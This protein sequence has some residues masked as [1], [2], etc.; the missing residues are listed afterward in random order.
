MLVPVDEQIKRLNA[1]RFQLD[2]M[3]VAGIT[4]DAIQGWYDTYIKNRKPVVAAIGDAKGTSL[5]SHVITSYSIHYTK[6]Y[7]GVLSSIHH[8]QSKIHYLAHHM[9]YIRQ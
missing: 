9:I 1:A 2:V 7:E 8:L 5:A 6:L 3:G 4:Q